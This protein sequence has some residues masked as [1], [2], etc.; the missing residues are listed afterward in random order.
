LIERVY[1]YEKGKIEVKLLH[2][3]DYE[4][5]ISN[6]KELQKEGLITGEVQ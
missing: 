2:A 4:E 3:Q 1:V 6:I 5:L